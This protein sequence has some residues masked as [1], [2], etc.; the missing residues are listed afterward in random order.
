MY[1]QVH[2][3]ATS[4]NQNFSFTY[5][6]TMACRLLLSTYHHESCQSSY[7]VCSSFPPRSSL[8]PLTLHQHS[9]LCPHTRDR[10]SLGE[11]CQGQLEEGGGEGGEEE[12]EKGKEEEAGKDNKGEGGRRRKRK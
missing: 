3:H 2:V 10:R 1:R 5:K 8:F 11:G 6:Y 9:S 7:F 12:G 4:N